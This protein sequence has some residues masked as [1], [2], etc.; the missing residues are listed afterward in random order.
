MT[1]ARET[2]DDLDGGKVVV[3]RKIRGDHR[4]SRDCW[5]NPGAFDPEEREAIQRFADKDQPS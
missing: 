4:I 1:Q 2:T 3:H 5:C